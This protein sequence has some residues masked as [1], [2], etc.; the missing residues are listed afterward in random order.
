MNI[1]FL[2]LLTALTFIAGLI[3]FA[4]RLWWQ[5]TRFATEKQPL[6]VEYARTFF[7]VFLVVLLIRSFVGQIFYV[8]T[9]SLEPTVMP[10]TFILVTQLWLTSPRD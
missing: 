5:K 8:P 9:G 4:D 10:G 7:P 2:F 3:Y 6:I 1:D